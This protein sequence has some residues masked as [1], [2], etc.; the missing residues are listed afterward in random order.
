LALK[1]KRGAFVTL[2]QG[3]EL[4]GCVGNLAGRAPLADEISELALSAALDDPRF[5]PATSTQGPIDLEI[6]VL[7][8]FKRISS[9][10]ECVVGKHGVLLRNGRRA[11]LLLPQVATERGW[12]TE[13]FLE[14]VS[15][16]SMLPENG[17]RDPKS[18][19]SVFEAQI[20]SRE[21]AI[22]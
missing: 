4:L 13:E 18:R 11:G 16:K 2:H 7:T 15:R 20:F 21:R 8:P 1:A 14:A 9:P 19:L 10:E 6:S 17:W 12:D 22:L 5:E 3:D